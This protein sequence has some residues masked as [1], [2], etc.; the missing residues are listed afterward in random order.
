MQTYNGFHAPSAFAMIISLVC[1]TIMMLPYF[2]T[3]VDLRGN[4]EDD[5]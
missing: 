2:V 5:D 1:F 3:P 4:G